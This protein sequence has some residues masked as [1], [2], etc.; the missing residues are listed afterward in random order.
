MCELCS[1]GE[2][3]VDAAIRRAGA[4]G[5]PRRTRRPAEG[6]A[7]VIRRR[8]SQGLTSSVA[9]V[10]WRASNASTMGMY[11]AVAVAVLVLVNLSLVL[12]LARPGSAEHDDG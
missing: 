3:L 8:G 9:G 12:L 5:C 1:S 2:R 4:R 10:L 11:L 7:R 6:A